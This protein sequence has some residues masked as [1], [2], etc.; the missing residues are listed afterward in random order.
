MQLF[1]W[2][3]EGETKIRTFAMTRLVMGNRPSANASQIAL[4][5]TGYI[6]DNHI[7]FPAAA[8]ALAR[9]SYVDN[10][11]VGNDDLESVKEDIKAVACVT[12]W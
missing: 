2:K 4:R 11:F 6:N 3:F 7:K 10:T 8:K 9:N 1:L 12:A 5:E